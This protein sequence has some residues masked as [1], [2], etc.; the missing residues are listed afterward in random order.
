MAA[1]ITSNDRPAQ[2]QTN[3]D[4][5][6]VPA[7][8][9]AE[10][11]EGNIPQVD[12]RTEVAVN[13]LLQQANIDVNGVDKSPKPS[14][15]YGIGD[16][17]IP[18]PTA[19]KVELTDDLR[20][21]GESF[22]NNISQVADEMLL[23]GNGAE[24]NIAPEGVKGTM[25]LRNI[26]DL[27]ANELLALFLK[28]NI[29]DPNNSVETQNEL[30]ELAT[31]LRQQGIQAA[32]DKS[33]TAQ[34]EMKSAQQYAD[35]VDMIGTIITIISLVLAVF[36]FGT[37]LALVA[38]VEAA[39]QAAIQTVKELTVQATKE[40]AQEIVKQAVK[41]AIAKF[42]ENFTQE[43]L[44]GIIRDKMQ[45]MTQEQ[46]QKMVQEKVTAQLTSQ[47][48]S[49][50]GNQLST[51]AIETISK[52]V[53][54]GAAKNVSKEMLSTM[55]QDAAKD[56]TGESIKGMSEEAVNGAIKESVNKAMTEPMQASVK[57]G[58]Q[59]SLKDYGQEG[60]LEQLSTMDKYQSTGMQEFADTS[61]MATSVMQVFNA[62]GQ[63][64]AAQKTNS[65]KEAQLGVKRSRF[66]A[67]Q[68]QKIIEQENEII[69]A[70]MESKNKTV[71]AIMK[72]MNAAF[73]TNNKVISASMSR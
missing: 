45:N 60:M 52:E 4:M 44:Q 37:S 35:Q 2:P 28:L 55:V 61:R 20:V 65:A 8:A 7:G 32:L 24:A 26:K 17:K 66:A 67:D 5:P 49:Q 1:N 22:A 46:L 64:T 38:A 62:G 10:A 59:T 42:G 18:P 12:G 3:A 48:T 19:P 69:Q 15:L 14:E 70:I 51:Q 11:K 39:K 9:P 33:V 23:K 47:L 57:E 56:I 16:D 40:V 72:M 50:F 68:Q 43:Q 25:D 71:D 63:Y 36:T 30:A 53:G 6:A 41:E 58:V 73:A 34:A 13:S 21:G 54:Q 31:T 29:D 27:S